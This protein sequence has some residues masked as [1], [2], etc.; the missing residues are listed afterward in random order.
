MRFS[1]VLSRHAV[2]QGDDY[3]MDEDGLRPVAGWQSGST[4]SLDDLGGSRVSCALLGEPGIGKSA[5][6][7]YLADADTS[8]VVELDEVTDVRSLR[9]HLERLDDERLGYRTLVLDG[10]DECPLPPKTLTRTL[11]DFLA[12]RRPVRVL[13]G[14]RT[15][16]WYQPLSESLMQRLGAF[17]VLELLPLSIHDI[18]RL[19]HERGVDAPTFLQEVRDRSLGSLASIPLTLDL[20]L[21]LFASDG[22]FPHEISGVYESGLLALVDE[23]DTGRA[24]DRTPA[25]NHAERLSVAARIA[26]TMLLCARSSIALRDV[27]A[28]PTIGVGELVGGDEPLPAGAVAVTSGLISSTLSTALFTGSGEGRLGIAHASFAAFLAARYLITHEVPEHQLRAL[29][30]RTNSLGRTSIPSPLREVAAWT[31]AMAP[32]R[33]SWLVHTDPA[34]VIAHAGVIADPALRRELVDYLLGQPAAG[35]RLSRRRWRLTYPG[36]AEQLHG[37]MRAALRGD[38]GRH[39]GDPTARR[40]H[41]AVLIARSSLLREAVPD[42]V[43]LVAR[44]GLN[45]VLRASAAFALSELDSKQAA[46]V[47][48]PVLTEV[49]QSPEHDPDDELRGQALSVCWPNYLS[50]AELVAAMTAPKRDNFIGSYSMFLRS[51]A[52]TTAEGRLA[53]VL[54]VLRDVGGDL[55]MNGSGRHGA[56][57][58][59]RDH[60]RVPNLLIEIVERLL[61]SNDLDRYERQVA[62]ALAQCAK[63]HGRVQSLPGPI[64]GDVGELVDRRAQRHRLIQGS[65]DYLSPQEAPLLLWMWKPSAADPLDASAAR[66]LTGDDLAWLFELGSDER[67]AAHATALLGA[68]FDPRDS[69][70]QQIAWE[71]REHPLFAQS[72]AWWFRAVPLDSEEARRSRELQKMATERLT[73]EGADD[74]PKAL[75]DAWERVRERDSEAFVGLTLRLWTEPETG[76]LDFR[77]GAL[78]DWP[79]A[80]LIA[81]D[82]IAYLEAA[83]AF[84]QSSD[85][86]Q[87]DWLAKP[88][89]VSY[90]A[91]VGY[92]VLLELHRAAGAITAL[93]VL[94]DDDWD[95]WAPAIVRCGY[96]SFV[97]VNDEDHAALDLELKRRVPESYKAVY[98]HWIRTSAE[99]GRSL[100]DLTPLDSVLDREL[101]V[102]LCRLLPVLSD[103]ASVAPDGDATS[104]DGGSAASQATA[105]AQRSLRSLTAFLAPHAHE[106]GLLPELAVLTTHDAPIVW[107]IG[108]VSLCAVATNVDGLLDLALARD[109]LGAA[110]AEEAASLR[111]S[112]RWNTLSESQI[113]RLVS[114]LCEGW[115]D[116]P[117][118]WERGTLEDS[119]RDWRDGLIRLLAERATDA[120]LRELQRIATDHASLGGIREHVAD[121]EE[122]QRDTSWVG[123]TPAEFHTLMQNARAT[124]VLDED[125]LYHAVLAAIERSQVRLRE[126]GQLLWNESAQRDVDGKVSGRL[127]APKYEPDVSALLRDHLQQDLRKDVVVNREVQVRQTS[128]KG[129]G[130]AVDVLIGGTAS[131]GAVVAI[132]IE[133]KGCWNSGLLTDLSSQ[134]V[135]DYLPALRAHRGIYVC[136]WFPPDQWSYEN[137]P[138]RIHANRLS[139]T[140]V[141]AEL[142]RRAHEAS[143]EQIRVSAVVLDV[144]RP[145]PSDRARRKPANSDSAK[146]EPGRG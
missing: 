28:P 65:L 76:H 133:V 25:G 42:I 79:S 131:D 101:A 26:A 9:E 29:L 12:G 82:Q 8:L 112:T 38:C 127:W 53:E 78:S 67:Y 95:R 43:D 24:K 144:P 63:A 22:G 70:Q 34:G 73:W 125:D 16:E 20:L 122:R 60:G 80:R 27:A 33:N 45:P 115:G 40:A 4:V 71:H 57:R 92:R 74:H 139:R 129:H 23:P 138:R 91:L 36:L 13:I 15:S 59:D 1:T 11:S 46:A 93:S 86:R 62:W 110:F 3:H 137:D 21:R 89:S 128:S 2:R 56:F 32:G 75:A 130:L 31:V 106:H 113:G 72:L 88:D 6:L 49:Q 61:V 41:T 117:V 142:Q 39:L 97:D 140:E 64:G 69:V 120:S 52:D 83:I 30:T 94:T 10:L 84:L 146:D 51:F 135:A 132:P 124:V 121:A 5:A 55:T 119:I 81:F 37:P 14:C 104:D 105:T 116:N 114:W 90:L 19:A 99:A 118:D 35:T 17:E 145:A 143:S 77:A 109:D 100:P 66:L 68:V 44:S 48:R 107:A 108:A 96:F 54:D 58:A 87:G 134:L 47:L 103:A 141:A 126:V 102:S 18:E 123:P 98:L 85:S 50:A 136:A 7:N 111:D